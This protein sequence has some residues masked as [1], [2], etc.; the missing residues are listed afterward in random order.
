M[1][2][3]VESAKQ[4]GG[5]PAESGRLDFRPFSPPR[6]RTALSSPHPASAPAPPTE[7]DL[8]CV[9]SVSLSRA[10]FS[11]SSARSMPPRRR[12]APPS[13]ECLASSRAPTRRGRLTTVSDSAAGSGFFSTADGSSKAR[14]RH[15]RSTTRRRARSARAASRPSTARSISICRSA[16]AVKRTTSFSREASEASASPATPTFRRRTAA[17]CVF[18]STTQLPSD[19]T[20]SSSTSRIRRRRHSDSLPWSA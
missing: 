6:L 16:W 4:F 12:P 2:P 15:R 17:V 20:R 18:T 14:S 11:H 9:Y 3:H 8:A 10:S 19:S 13:S 1:R 5:S 7:E